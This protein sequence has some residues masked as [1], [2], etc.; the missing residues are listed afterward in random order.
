MNLIPE[1]GHRGKGR[2][3]LC[4]R[5]CRL[6]ASRQTGRVRWCVIDEAKNYRYRK[7]RFLPLLP[8]VLL[9]VFLLAASINHHLKDHP[10]QHSLTPLPASGEVGPALDREASELD[11]HH[12]DTDAQT[13]FV[14]PTRD[15][16]LYSR[17]KRGWDDSAPWET[18]QGNKTSDVIIW[19][20]VTSRGD[21]GARL[22]PLMTELLRGLNL[23]A[24][25]SPGSA[26]QR[27]ALEDSGW[28]IWPQANES[29]TFRV[30][31]NST[32][33]ED[34]S[35]SLK[36]E[37]E[38]ELVEN[39]TSSEDVEREWRLFIDATQSPP[40]TTEPMAS[41][42]SEVSSQLNKENELEDK[43]SRKIFGATSADEEN[44]RAIQG[45]IM[46][47]YIDYTTDPCEDFYQYACGNWESQ[48]PI[49]KDK[50]VYD[51]FEI[52]RESLDLLLKDV[53]EDSS[54]SEVARPGDGDQVDA[55]SKARNLYK[56]CMNETVLAE[57]GARPLLDLLRHLGGWPVLEES[58]DPAGFD[59][60]QLMAR[61][62]L[63]NNDILV[64]QWVAPDIKHSDEYVIQFDQTSLGLQTRD[65]YLEPFG[66][67]YLDAYKN[68]IIDIATKLGASLEQAATDAYD[69]V[70]FETQLAQIMSS[71]EDRRNITAMY[72]RISLNELCQLVPSIDW[73]RYLEIVLQRPVNKS[74]PVVVFGET[75]LH[76]LVGLL[77]RTSNRTVAN[78]LLWRF[79]RHRTSNLDDRFLEAKQRFFL[80]LFG[81]EESP[82]RWKNCVNH[83]NTNMGM[84]VGAM[85]VRKY[86]DE[87]SKN[88]TL[89]LTREIM[90]SFKEILNET[91]WLD[92]E[93]KKFAAQKAEAMML[94]I[95][96]PDFILSSGELNERYREL[97]INPDEY[98]ENTLS[99]LQFLAKA[100]MNRL[101]STVNKTL[102]NAPPAFINAFYSRNKN[103]IMFPAGILQPPFY[104]HRFPPSLN[105]GGI[106]V[107]IG[108]EITHGFDD[109]G[110]LFDKDGNMHRWWGDQA[111]QA[112]NQ[113]IQCLIDQYSRYSMKDVDVHIDGTNTQGE[114]IADNGGIKQAY[115]AYQSR[116]R[117]S[118]GKGDYLPGV[119]ATGAQLFFLNF[120]QVWC[121]ASRPEV[122]RSK[123]KN[124]SH[125][126]GK[127]RVIGTL[128]N[129]REFASA[130]GCAENSPMNPAKK[131]EVW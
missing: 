88:E 22:G 105:Y 106:G 102:W 33:F 10:Q 107:V 39:V 77:S 62:R 120:A 67:K 81:R 86:F 84:A 71:P 2:C 73:E 66:V 79:V 125:S 6:A 7:L 51:T 61:L 127:F 11:E 80:V 118:G 87:S 78:Y 47:S 16:R 49:P 64:G 60:L 92:E 89:Q 114:N 38:D 98:F 1:P 4:P 97:V 72:Q 30:E 94:K 41:Y 59:W 128:S 36:F 25:G 19:S 123:L 104:H 48:N 74:D 54:S 32:A 29:S 96:Y 65:Y 99:V 83:V 5:C 119:N 55:I 46:N 130:F 115:K 85:F 57:R 40:A 3:R 9:P 131:C 76:D 14:P 42:K 20:A 124:A 116:L 52:L 68:F 23:S 113:R 15:F 37:N 50:S 75:Y 28:T 69:I 108:H 93:T 17:S 109:K 70:A 27:N 101:G 103:Q 18:Y 56:S 12:A 35:T 95:G 110:R 34:N 117:Q 90:Q 112:F 111:V 45:E 44:I 82:P 100:E 43:L 53:L 24:S 129:S 58:W 21:S 63:Y 8:V 31:N 91:S 26:D 121:G 126:P 13:S 122:T